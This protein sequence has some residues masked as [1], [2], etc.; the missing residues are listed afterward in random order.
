LAFNQ[1]ICELKEEK[2]T[3]LLK[4][5]QNNDDLN[6]LLGFYEEVGYFDEFE[7]DD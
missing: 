7:Y 2:L 5:A 3:Y 4:E 6:E 1:G